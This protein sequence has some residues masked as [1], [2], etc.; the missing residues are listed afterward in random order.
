MRVSLPILALATA[1]SL[2]FWRCGSDKDEKK[3]GPAPP[4]DAT[5]VPADWD[6][7]SDYSGS[8]L[9]AVDE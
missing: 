4:I 8:V 9:Q 3:K 1:V 7:K 5:G 6:G 2:M